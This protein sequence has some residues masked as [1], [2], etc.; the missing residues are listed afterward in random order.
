MGRL[1]EKNLKKRS[2]VT[3]LDTPLY[4]A[5]WAQ[6]PYPAN[7]WKVFDYEQVSSRKHTRFVGWNVADFHA[8]VKRGELMPHT[9]FY[10][11]SSEGETDGEYGVSSHS[12]GDC[13]KSSFWFADNSYCPS[14]AWQLHE[15]EL[16][17][18]APEQ[19]YQ[20]VQEA[21]AKIYSS[22]H[23]T[24]TCL[25]ELVQLK[26]L[27][28][29][30]AKTLLMVNLP[31]GGFKTLKRVSSEWLA[32]RYGWRTL[33]YDIEDIRKAVDKLQTGETRTRFSEKAGTTTYHSTINT[34]YEEKAHFTLLH[35]QEDE[36]EIGLRGAVTADA[37]IAMFSFNPLVTG[38]EII[39]FSFVLDWFLTV[40]KAIQAAS[41]LAFQSSYSAS[42]GYRVKMKRT[43][44]C[45]IDSTKPSYCGGLCEQD[46]WSEAELE[47]RIPCSVPTTP[48]LTVKLNTAKVFDLMALVLQRY[49]R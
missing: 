30:A 29:G 15:D 35:T 31:K 25:A 17:A 8:R 49:R 12:T 9:P 33:L 42:W 18:Y 26:H 28:I 47:E 7:E 39:P 20:Y 19:T 14:I 13:P 24:L 48:H 44:Y 36:V 10:R 11:Y 6:P 46:G 3:D 43:Y 22:G 34:W 32:G 45:E 41:F 23:D 27:F 40:G 16:R 1:V 37:Q 38:W 2:A 21:A 4:G 5:V